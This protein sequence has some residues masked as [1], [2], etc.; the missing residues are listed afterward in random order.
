MDTE[1]AAANHSDKATLA[2][3]VP[4]ADQVAGST[5]TAPTTS[6]GGA[7]DHEV[8]DMAVEEIVNERAPVPGGATDTCY[9]CREKAER[10][11]QT[12]NP[13]VRC[14]AAGCVRWVH[15]HCT[16]RPQDYDFRGF[17]CDMCYTTDTGL[18]FDAR[19]RMWT[20]AK[21]AWKPRRPTKLIVMR[22]GQDLT[23]AGINVASLT[24]QRRSQVKIVLTALRTTGAARLRDMEIW[25]LAKQTGANVLPPIRRVR[26]L[27]TAYGFGPEVKTETTLYRRAL[28]SKL[29]GI[30]GAS[31]KIKIEDRSWADYARDDSGTKVFVD[32]ARGCQPFDLLPLVDRD[33]VLGLYDNTSVDDTLS[34]AMYRRGVTLAVGKKIELNARGKSRVFVPYR[35]LQ[36]VTPESLTV[37]TSYGTDGAAAGTV[38]MSI[39]AGLVD[40]GKLLTPKQRQQQDESNGSEEG[41]DEDR[42]ETVEAGSRRTSRRGQPRPNYAEASSEDE[43]VGSGRKRGGTKGKAAA[44]RR[45]RQAAAMEE[46]VEVGAPRQQRQAAAAKADGDTDIEGGGA[47]IARRQVGPYGHG[48]LGDGRA[49]RVEQRGRTRGVGRQ[50]RNA[51]KV[52]AAMTAMDVDTKDG[53]AGVEHSRTSGVGRQQRSA[54]KDAA[55]E[56]A[57]DVEMENG[58]AGGAWHDGAAAMARQQVGPVGDVDM[59][60]DSGSAQHSDGEAGGES[61]RDGRNVAQQQAGPLGGVAPRQP[62]PADAAEAVDDAD[63]GGDNVDPTTRADAAAEDKRQTASKKKYRRKRGKQKHQRLR[64]DD[65]TRRD[66]SPDKQ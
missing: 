50:Q 1:G 19:E 7:G 40:E 38:V 45:Q 36:D 13:R 46:T 18:D 32:Y 42:E 64:R 5:G 27:L 53:V 2:N 11:K 54:G 12:R 28:R 52:D 63:M 30:T 39:V 59:D 8:T 16:G 51:G 33:W 62:R 4:T 56:T 37:M 55:A 60:G 49:G 66:P 14:S 65:Q 24:E 43:D 20:T 3:T 10:G 26:I 58:A 57:A 47:E 9:Q 31:V 44:P 29:Q 35:C 17:K 61:K 34:D 21:V 41:S 48:D 23:S 22:R 25:E 6:G 15:Q